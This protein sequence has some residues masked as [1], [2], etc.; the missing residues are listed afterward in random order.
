MSP[1]PLFRSPRVWLGLLLALILS[2]AGGVFTGLRGGHWTN[3]A[4]AAADPNGSVPTYAPERLFL[5]QFLGIDGKIT[6]LSGYRGRPMLLNFWASWCAPCVKEMPALSVLN[7]KYGPVGVQ[8]VGVGVD[9]AA[10]V[11]QFLRRVR[12]DYPIYVA[13]GGGVDLAR[14]LGDQIGGLPYTVLIDSAGRIRWVQLGGINPA[15][16]AAALDQLAANP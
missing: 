12:V 9:S 6:S 3:E 7:R 2:T 8:F 13:G 16:V 11:N 14:A 1:T 15:Q 10:N 4:A 5:T